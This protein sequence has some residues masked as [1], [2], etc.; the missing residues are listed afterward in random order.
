[1]SFNIKSLCLIAVLFVMTATCLAAELPSPS[2][3]PGPDPSK[4]V[5]RWLRADGGYLLQLT[6]PGPDGQLQ[7]AYFNPRPI[8]VAR[9]AWKHQEGYLG[10][11]VELR[12]P[13]YPGSTYTLAYDPA[14]DRLVGI[15]YQAAMQQ[16][17]DVEFKRTP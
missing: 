16:K 9:A 5:G 17:F 11:F 7:A 14:S 2:S 13:N 15:Y 12:A 4:L 1:M 6:D 10:A 3:E 8:N